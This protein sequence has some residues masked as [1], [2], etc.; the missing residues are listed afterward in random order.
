VLPQQQ[1]RWEEK[2]DTNS[3][4]ILLSVMFMRLSLGNRVGGEKKRARERDIPKLK[5]IRMN[6]NTNFIN[7]CLTKASERVRLIYA[8]MAAD[9]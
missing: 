5:T 2:I 6:I 9:N 7:F 4:T 8:I 3:Q 1:H